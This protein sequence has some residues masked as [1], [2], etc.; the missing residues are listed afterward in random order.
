MDSRQELLLELLDR[1]QEAE[2]GGQPLEVE[3]LCADCPDLLAG[4]RRLIELHREL[5]GLADCDEP[6]TLAAGGAA[7]ESA[8]DLPSIP[9][10][11]LLRELGRGGMGVVFEAR[12]LGLNRL[13]ALKVVLASRLAGT[14]ALAR[15][16]SEAQ[17]VA[18]LQHANVVQ[19]FDAGE[20]DGR[21]YFVM[22]LVRGGS[23]K[24]RLTGAPLPPVRVAE[25]VLILARAV[26]AAHARGI[27]HRDLTPANVLLDRDDIG[28]GASSD[29]AA[30][31]DVPKISDFGLAKRVGAEQTGTNA[32]M[33]TPSYMPPEQAGSAKAVGPTAD[34][35]A[36]GAILYECLTGR[37]PFRGETALDTIQQVLSLEPVPP[38]RLQP[39]VPRDLSVI[40]LKCLEKVPARRYPGAASLAE[41]LQRFLDGKAI[42]ARP[43]AAPERVYKW[44][45]RHPALT[46]TLVA[47]AA[48][49]VGLIGHL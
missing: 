23:L 2:E 41:D 44:A 20:H 48:L 35:Y 30:A 37:P 32:I 26:Q 10:Y 42:H 38:R 9:G 28:S 34:V 17:T 16:R 43:P 14:E 18:C 49:L 15:F 3:R 6:V 29:A 31:W 5:K 19:V 25:L 8:P 4:L 7:P 12:H 45:W 13:V 1:Y 27:V 11:E 39:G 24:D 46:V 36:L 47:G 21:P 22:E 40:C 33:G